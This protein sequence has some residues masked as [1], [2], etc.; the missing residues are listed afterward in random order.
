M[1]VVCACESLNWVWPRMCSCVRAS[2]RVIK[3]RIRL[4]LQCPKRLCPLS[5]LISMFFP[6]LLHHYSP[7]RRV[8]DVWY[9]CEKGLKELPRI[10]PISPLNWD[11]HY[12]IHSS[13]IILHCYSLGSFLSVFRLFISFFFLS[14]SVYLTSVYSLWLA[15]NE[16]VQEWECWF[17]PVCR[18]AVHES[19]LNP[20]GMFVAA[21]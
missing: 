14:F 5:E 16:N 9:A 4:A 7:L 12:Y 18:S 8:E 21:K 15:R 1:A 17:S 2:E 19:R 6:D 13:S 3:W 11:L 10:V 20:S